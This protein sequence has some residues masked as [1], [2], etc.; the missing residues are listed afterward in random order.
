M[1]DPQCQAECTIQTHEGLSIQSYNMRDD[2]EFLEEFKDLCHF[3]DIF[4]Q[5]D[6]H[7]FRL[8]VD[9][10]HHL[11]LHLALRKSF[12]GICC[13]YTRFDELAEAACASLLSG[14]CNQLNRLLRLLQAL[15]LNSE[16]VLHFAGRAKLVLALLKPHQCA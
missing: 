10:V 3:W 6:I 9:P 7:K 14:S 15:R 5:V 11:D 4:S 13:G 16:P 12:I 2:V 8:G 1:L